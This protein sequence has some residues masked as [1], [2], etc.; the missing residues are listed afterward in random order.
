MQLYIQGKVPWKST[1]IVHVCL[2]ETFGPE[3]KLFCF[4]LRENIPENIAAILLFTK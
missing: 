2:K 4:P 1:S 3:S